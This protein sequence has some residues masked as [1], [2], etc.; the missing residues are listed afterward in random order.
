MKEEKRFPLTKSHTHT[1]LC[2]VSFFLSQYYS[3]HLLLLLLLNLRFLFPVKDCKVLCILYT[4]HTGSE[5]LCLTFHFVLLRF[6]VPL[7]HSHACQRSRAFHIRQTLV[8]SFHDMLF[9]CWSI[10]PLT[11]G[12]LCCDCVCVRA[13]VGCHFYEMWNGKEKIVCFYTSTRFNDSK[14]RNQRASID[15]FGANIQIC[16]DR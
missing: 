16:A 13:Y 9:E 4:V 12:R 8:V 11:T 2:R 10:L 5:F 14:I 6:Q 7:S 3:L 15:F 1:I